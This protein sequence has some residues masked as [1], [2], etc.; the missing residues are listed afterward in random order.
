MVIME[1]LKLHNRPVLVYMIVAVVVVAAMGLG[2]CWL[3]DRDADVAE[4]KE[5]RIKAPDGFYVTE[6]PTPNVAE[7]VNKVQ[8][9]VLHHTAT[10]SVEKSLKILT[11]PKSG[12]SCHVL[13]DTDGSRY[14]LAP[15]EAI[16]WHAGR[17]RLNGK[18]GCNN[19]TVGIEFQGNTLEEPLTDKQIESAIDYMLPIMEE[20]NIPLKDIVTHEQ[21]RDNYIKAHPKQKTPSKV[22]VTPDEYARF[23]TALN[24]RLHD[25]HKG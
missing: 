7:G 17:S 1:R 15:P 4:C 2:Y 25:T 23:M 8:G 20:H 9:I 5:M 11:D 24:D 10:E 3:E 13:I 16:T 19:F 12:V 21:I 6:V 18:D 22:D 14:V